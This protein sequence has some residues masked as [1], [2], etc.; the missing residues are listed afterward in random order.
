MPQHEPQHLRHWQHSQQQDKPQQRHLAQHQ[1]IEKTMS[2]P[3]MIIPITGHLQN[4][5]A[6][7]LSQLE[8]AVLASE[9]VLCRPDS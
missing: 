8:R 6:I 3:K 4:V 1:T 2:D 7:Q 9:T 5:K